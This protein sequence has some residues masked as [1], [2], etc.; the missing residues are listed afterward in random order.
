M[1]IKC[2]F[3]ESELL[4]KVLINKMSCATLHKVSCIA[5]E[6]FARK[7]NA[8]QNNTKGLCIRSVVVV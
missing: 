1:T 6:L 7:M 4:I 8:N 2:E 5:K 3:L